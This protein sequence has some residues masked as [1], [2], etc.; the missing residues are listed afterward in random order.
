MQRSLKVR[1]VVLWHRLPVWVR[2]G[3][4]AVGII[5]LAIWSTAAVVLAFIWYESPLRCPP[6]MGCAVEDTSGC[7]AAWAPWARNATPC[8][9]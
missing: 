3:G 7:R 8:E 4:L 2:V 6:T 5:L 1:F 9:K